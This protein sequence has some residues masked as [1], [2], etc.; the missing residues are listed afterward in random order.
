VTDVEA[1]TFEQAELELADI[2]ARLERGDVGLD[3]AIEL[4]RRGELLH[5]RCTTLL[6]VA[7][8]RIEQLAAADGDS[9]SP[10]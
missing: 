2:V 8:G 7:E 6:D 3:E 9:T 1:L 5:R 4:W 10:E